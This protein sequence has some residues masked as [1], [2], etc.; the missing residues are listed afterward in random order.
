MGAIKIPLRVEK[1]EYAEQYQEIVLQELNQKIE[2]AQGLIRTVLVQIEND[3]NLNYLITTIHHAISDG[4]SSIALHS[5]IFKY[6]QKLALG[7][8]I[9][10]IN[11]HPPLP[12]FTELIPLRMQGLRGRLKIFSLLLK[13]LVESIKYKPQAFKKEK[14]VPLE[15]CCCGMIQKKINYDQSIKLKEFCKINHTTIHSAICAAVLIVSARKK[16]VPEEENI[17][18]CCQ[19]AVNL[20]KLVK[21]AIS[22]ETISTFTSGVNTFHDI[23]KNT[24]FWELAKEVKRRID[25]SLKNDD[26][27]SKL[28]IFDKYYI[29]LLE[30]KNNKFL[31]RYSISISNIGQVSI[32]KNYGIFELE[33]ISFTP[34]IKI[35][36]N[37]NVSVS[38]FQ[39]RMILNFTYTEP[40][41]SKEIIEILAN[42]VIYE[43]TNIAVAY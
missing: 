14:Y 43:L 38:S 31:Y 9:D 24:N 39:D 30:N 23:N 6:Y 35:G 40:Y 10:E 28:F 36:T 25:I 16:A 21:P 7:E 32:P 2:S 27:F 4:L 8:I 12:P 41:M 15:E 3:N 1:R 22:N 19:S 37:L 18:L 17:Q 26:I 42:N 5:Q 11:I 20:R 34:A 33:E 13:S 29:S